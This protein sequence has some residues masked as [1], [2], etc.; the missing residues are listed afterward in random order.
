MHRVAGKIE[1]DEKSLRPVLPHHHHLERVDIRPAGFVL[2]L[3][4]DRVPG[5]HEVQ[6]AD[7]LF[8]DGGDGVDWGAC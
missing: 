1:R 5:V 8:G 7:L 4:L 2:L 6:F 3:D